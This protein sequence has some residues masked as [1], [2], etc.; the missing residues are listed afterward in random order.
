MDLLR[1]GSNI[2]WAEKENYE[3]PVEQIYKNVNVIVLNLEVDFE[4]VNYIKEHGIVLFIEE[5]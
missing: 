1:I 4:S 3:D 2:D 5:N